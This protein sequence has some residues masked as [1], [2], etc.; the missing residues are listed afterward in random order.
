ME[1]KQEPIAWVC[2]DCGAES[3]YRV[4]HN[5]KAPRGWREDDKGYH[6]NK[7]RGKK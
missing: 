4:E 7:C 3:T 6:C 5:E 2:T 1:N